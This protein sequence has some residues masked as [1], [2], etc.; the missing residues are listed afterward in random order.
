MATARVDSYPVVNLTS[1]LL[2]FLLVSS[3]LYIISL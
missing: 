1:I 2:L 3:H